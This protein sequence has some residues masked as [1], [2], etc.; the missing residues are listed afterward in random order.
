MK[1]AVLREV[2][3]PLEIETV[4]IGKPGP[5]EVLIRTK[6]AGVCHSDLHFV[7]GSYSHPLPAVLGH[8]SAGIVEAV[9]SEVR[10]VKVGD[11]VITCLNPYCGH[12]EVC[13]TGHMNLCISPETRR[14][15][16]DEPRLFKEDLGG[17]R[18]P[19]AQFLNLSSFAE[20][21]LVH[22][23]AC[24]AI[25]RDMPFDLAALIGC[26]VMTGVGAVIH[27]SSVRPGETVAVIGC[28]GV[29]LA[30]V[31]GAAIAGAG[32]IIAIDRVASKLELARQFG[33]TDLIDASEGDVVKQVQELTGGGVHHSFEAIGLKITA[34][35]SFRMLR[36]GGTANIIGMIPVG[37]KIELHGPDFLGE[38]KIQGSYMGSNRFPVDMPRLVDFYMSGKLKLDQMIS[39][40]IKLEEINS[41]FDELKRG[42]LARSVIVFD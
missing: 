22:E 41:A 38:K 12:C 13:L 24:V 27:T 34:E 10:T 3:K 29:G 21:M 42:E 15:K 36:R 20:M 19:M 40:R 30:T 5:R 23:H 18:G 37:T 8:E 31:N 28:G 39:R 14:A 2:G 33:A 9:G 1:A 16:T 11:H 17:Q 4:S 6:A 25:R 7:E 32:R 35:Q 26:S